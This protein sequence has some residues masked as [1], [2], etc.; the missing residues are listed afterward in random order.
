MKKSLILLLLLLSASFSLRGQFYYYGDNSQLT[1]ATLAVVDS[2]SAEPLPFASVYLTEAKD[3][4]I[5]NF[6]LTD[7][8]GK[9][10]IE[11]WNNSSCTDMIFSAEGITKDGYFITGQ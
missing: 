8:D 9:A 6:T 1:R 5:A 3:S 11:F 10:H 7:A 2:T 4:S